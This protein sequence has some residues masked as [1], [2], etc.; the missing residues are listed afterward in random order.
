MATVSIVDQDN[1]PMAR[2]YLRSCRYIPIANSR[3][4]PINTQKVFDIANLQLQQLLSGIVENCTAGDNLVIV[5]HGLTQALNIPLGCSNSA[6]DPELTSDVL[7]L[8]C[9]RRSHAELVP[10]LFLTET[11]IANLRGLRQ[12]V[13]DLHLQRVELVA[14]EVGSYESTLSA[15]Q[16]F[17]A[18]QVVGGP[19]VR[20]GWVPASFHEDNAYDYDRYSQGGQG[21]LYTIDGGHVGFHVSAGPARSLRLRDARATSRSTLQAWAHRYFPRRTDITGLEV[22]IHGHWTMDRMVLPLEPG[23]QRNMREFSGSSTSELGLGELDL[24]GI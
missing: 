18:C 19:R 12:R 9:S 20:Y 17:F 7:N 2:D 5:S 13:V 1:F 14:C 16:R 22:T 23:F 4:L 3:T 11:Q 24:E 21:Q 10:L 6:N 15:I 8:L